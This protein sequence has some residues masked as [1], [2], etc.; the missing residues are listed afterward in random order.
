[1]EINQ[2]MEVNKMDKYVKGYL[3]ALNDVIIQLKNYQVLIETIKNE[4]EK[5]K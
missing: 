5:K 3:D 2:N 1:M 4:F